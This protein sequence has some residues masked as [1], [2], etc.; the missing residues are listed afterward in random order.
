MLSILWSNYFSSCFIIQCQKYHHATLA[1]EWVMKSVLEEGGIK[2]T[3]LWSVA[4]HKRL[5]WHSCGMV[6]LLVT[7]KTTSELCRSFLYFTSVASVILPKYSINV[8]LQQFWF[9]MNK[10]RPKVDQKYGKIIWRT[11]MRKSLD[12]LLVLSFYLLIYKME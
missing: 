12:F 4:W 5:Y 3:Q 7:G 11:V 8:Y 10:S 9:N 1:Q 6:R 2:R